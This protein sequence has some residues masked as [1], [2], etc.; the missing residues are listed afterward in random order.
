MNIC[1]HVI[2]SGRVQGVFYRASAKEKAEELGLTGWVRNKSDGTVEAC[3]EGEENKVK[4]MIKWCHQG[5][6]FSKV[7]NVE[8]VF[9]DDLNHYKNFNVRY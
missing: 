8:V 4:D 9:K 5:P 2:I 1:A 7:K 6:R 3:F